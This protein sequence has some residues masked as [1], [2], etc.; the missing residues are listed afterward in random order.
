[1]NKKEK[2]AIVLLNMG[3][4]T[5][6]KELVMFLTNMFNDKNIIT[7]KS[8]LLR[9][10][11]AKMILFFRLNK[12]KEN[13]NQIN[14]NS[15][16][17]KITKKLIKKLQ[18]KFPDAYIAPAMRYTP[19]FASK[20]VKKI[21]NKNINNIFLL[22]MYPQYSTTTVKS[23]L[24]D[25]IEQIEQKIPQAKITYIKRFY[26]NK[27]VTKLIVDIIEE[28]L[29]KN[30]DISEYN[31][32]FS[33]HSLPKKII[34][35]GDS[36]EQELEHQISLIKKEL[37]YRS[38]TPCDIVLA[39]QSKLGPVKWLE[40]SLEYVIKN[41]PPVLIEKKKKTKKVKKAIVYPISFSIDNAETIQELSIETK[42]LAKERGY[43]K[44][45]VCEV[46]NT[47]DKFVDILEEIINN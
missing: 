6:D 43:D 33:A 26:E 10:F 24:E 15:P 11:I 8:D 17:L 2:Q 14:N 4:I 37:L 42:K 9:R 39:Y 29:P 31:L 36:Y 44:F 7:T 30:E 28:T 38:L 34:E 40:P 32:I 47:R 25:I 41:I 22:P 12:A 21:K 46:F 16:I 19:P 5:S 45:L 1:M 35:N 3:G 23:S 18:K 13:Y 27:K 20:I